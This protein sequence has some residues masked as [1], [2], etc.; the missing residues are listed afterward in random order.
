MEKNGL[1]TEDARSNSIKK[2][3]NNSF[4][5]RTPELLILDLYDGCIKFLR[6]ALDGFNVESYEKINNNLNRADAIVDEL[7]GSLNF[8]KGGEIAVNFRKLYTFIDRSITASNV[9]KDRQKAEDAL[10]II[11]MMRDTWSEGVVKN[12]V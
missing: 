1:A 5:T 9:K 7:N 2:Y 8:E 4:L 11:Q 3:V 6:A 12:R 10:K